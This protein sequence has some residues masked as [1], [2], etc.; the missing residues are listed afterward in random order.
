MTDQRSH[1]SA[2]LGCEARAVKSQQRS[3]RAQGSIG[4][5]GQKSP[6]KRLEQSLTMSCL[7]CQAQSAVACVSLN[8]GN[9][10]LIGKVQ[11]VLQKIRLAEWV[12]ARLE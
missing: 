4:I 11:Q 3:E 10:Q 7:A 8:L 9:G 1:G 2:Q 12:L 6:H 5:A